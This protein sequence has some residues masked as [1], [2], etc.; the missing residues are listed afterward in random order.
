M[1]SAGATP[2]LPNV[3]DLAGKSRFDAHTAIR[4]AGYNYH[5][6]TAGGYV[7]YRH[8]SGAEIH[9]RPNGEVIRLGPP[10]VPS[11]GGRA[12]HPRIDYQGH[13]IPTH[14]TGEFVAPLPG[15]SPP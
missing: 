14:S 1:S 6:T 4:Q 2:S 15:R 7:R 9:I 10:V 12:Y 11:G 5:G 13:P 8:P 3:P